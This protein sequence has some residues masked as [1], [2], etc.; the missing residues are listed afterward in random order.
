MKKLS[1]TIFTF[2][3]SF[4]PKLILKNLF[5]IE[6][7]NRQAINNVAMIY[8]EKYRTGKQI[9][10]KHRLI[11]Y[12]NF[13][14]SKISQNENILDL[15][16]GYGA[17][18]FSIAQRIQGNVVGIDINKESIKM[19]KTHF[20]LKNLQFAVGDGCNLNKINNIQTIVLSNVLEHINDR[21]TFFKNCNLQ[22]KPKRWLI[23]V[24]LKNRDWSVALRDELGIY[25][26]LDNDHKI[27][28]TQQ[29]FYD[30]I[31][32]AGMVIKTLEIQWGEIWAE[33]L[34]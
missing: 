9:H 3:I 2:I 21:K 22:I 14:I 5:F 16:C 12:H 31:T 8:E 30:E 4:N 34:V 25:S 26:Y 28:Y 27:E 13:F 15:G 20:Y 33:V 7:I 17:V 29:S 23:R 6:V 24:P 10:P 32:A 19:A 11:G 18:A 1:K